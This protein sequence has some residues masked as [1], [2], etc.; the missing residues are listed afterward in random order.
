LASINPEIL[1]YA[2]KIG[3][4]ETFGLAAE[5][6]LVICNPNMLMHVAGAFDISSIVVIPEGF[7]SA[8]R[9]S[10]EWGYPVS[11]VLGPCEGHPQDFS[12][13]EVMNMVNEFLHKRSKEKERMTT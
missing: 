7:E 4:R 13:A 2:G 9:Q 3:L 10:A 8:A 11:T 12:A 5:A 1:D 6:D